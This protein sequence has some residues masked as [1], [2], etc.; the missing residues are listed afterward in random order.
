MKS[1]DFDSS[2]GESSNSAA[3]EQSSTTSIPQSVPIATSS[4]STATNDESLDPLTSAVRM[5]KE[6]LPKSSGIPTDQL[7]P[8]LENDIPFLK[9]M[10]SMFQAFSGMQSNSNGDSSGSP[11]AATLSSMFSALEA[12]SADGNDSKMIE[13]M[14]TMLLAKDHF[15]EPMGDFTRQFEEFLRKSKETNSRDSAAK[16]TTADWERFDKQLERFRQ[17]LIVYET[18]PAEKHAEAVTQLLSELEALG[19]PPN[20]IAEQMP[21]SPFSMPGTGGT[22]GSPD[23]CV[24]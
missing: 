8:G 5:L 11:D 24:M 17:I 13:T 22:A 4:A 2:A 10:E 21:Q 3:G 9:D 14:M 20:E 1:R 23:C 15:Y 7:P 12:G 16:Y 18:E 6:G 19:S